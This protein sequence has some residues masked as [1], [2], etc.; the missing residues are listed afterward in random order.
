MVRGSLEA[1]VA[2]RRQKRGKDRERGEGSLT[3]DK[4]LLLWFNWQLTFA[5]CSRVNWKLQ[6]SAYARAQ[7]TLSLCTEPQEGLSLGLRV[8]EARWPRQTSL[9]AWIRG[10]HMQSEGLISDIP[11]HILRWYYSGPLDRTDPVLQWKVCLQALD[12][13][14]HTWVWSQLGHFTTSWPWPNDLTFLI[15][16]DKNDTDLVYV[17]V[18]SN[19]MPCMQ[20][21]LLTYF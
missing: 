3:K 15:T 1:L 6:G 11:S 19:E 10:V 17:T 7:K 13:A 18:V 20:G 9:W 8:M 2:A 21:L 5:L 12:G 14:R 4:L 16:W